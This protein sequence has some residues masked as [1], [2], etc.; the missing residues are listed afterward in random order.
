MWFR[1]LSLIWLYLASGI[2]Y[3]AAGK[4]QTTGYVIVSVLAAAAAW[5]SRRDL[6]RMWRAARVRRAMAAFGAPLLWS[7]CLLAMIRVYS[8]GGWFGGWLEHFHRCLYFLQ[9]F[10][11]TGP[12]FG[13]YQLAARPPLM[14]LV[15]AFF[16]GQTAD[17]FDIFQLIF[18]FLNLLVFLPAVLI[19]PALA[20]PALRMRW[21]VIWTLAALFAVNPV[22]M[23]NVTYAWTKSLSVFFVILGLALYLAANRK[24]DSTRMVAAFVALA[25][26]LLTHYRAGPYIVIA[27]GHYLFVGFRRRTRRAREMAAIVA[28]GSLLLLTWFGWS[29]AV[30]GARVTGHFQHERDIQAG[31]PGQHRRKDRGQPV[32]HVHP[33]FSAARRVLQFAPAQS[34]GRIARAGIPGVSDQPDLRHGSGGRIACR[35]MLVGALAP[36]QE[37]LRAAILAMGDTPAQT[38]YSG[39]VYNGRNFDLPMEGSLSHSAWKN[40]FHKHHEALCRE[41]LAQLHRDPPGDARF[42]SA[43]ATMTTALEHLLDQGRSLWHGW[44]DRHGCSMAYVGDAFGSGWGPGGLVLA[45][46]IGSLWMLWHWIPAAVPR[47]TR[48]KPIESPKRRRSAKGKAR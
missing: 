8:G 16:L 26:G 4:E 33:G 15:G 11:V 43:A 6:V 12:I 23:E 18:L 5:A 3:L 17:R 13:D 39:L 38:V 32:G 25:A 40:W 14:N 9:R 42:A 47:L 37:G 10:P 20:G 41:W 7:V 46:W 2:L 34:H 21:R 30:F 48:H 36:R 27:A 1:R 24:R 19:L 45:M 22:V 28:L 35:G 44:Y 29:V 31:I